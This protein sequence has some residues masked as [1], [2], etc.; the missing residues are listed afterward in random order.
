MSLSDKIQS[1]E[2]YSKALGDISFLADGKTVRLGRK[3]KVVVAP[4]EQSA[5]VLVDAIVAS[6]KVQKDKIDEMLVLLAKNCEQV[7]LFSNPEVK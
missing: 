1:L 4:D 5:E 3:Y 7:N 2:A 6:I